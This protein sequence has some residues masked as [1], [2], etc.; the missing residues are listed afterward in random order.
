MFSYFPYA[1]SFIDGEEGVTVDPALLGVALVVAPFVFVVVA[2]V[3]RNAR[4]PRQVLLAMGLLLGLGLSIGLISPILG[5]SAGFGVGVAITLKRPD[6]PDQLRRRLVAVIAA[7]VYTTLLL[8]IAP[9]AAVVTGAVVP[10]LM[11]G[12][13]DEYGAWRWARDHQAPSPQQT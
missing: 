1:A 4:A 8:F 10:I 7:V 11:V 2:L 6:I 3:S 9:P 12:F 13:A 5:A